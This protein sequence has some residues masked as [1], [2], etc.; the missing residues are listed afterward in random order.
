MFRRSST[1]PKA[2]E[3]KGGEVRYRITSRLQEFPEGT[4][5]TTKVSRGLICSAPSE[6]HQLPHLESSAG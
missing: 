2:T 6:V 5:Q 3:A 4:N 1:D